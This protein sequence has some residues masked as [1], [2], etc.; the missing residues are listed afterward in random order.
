MSIEA[1]LSR[2][3]IPDDLVVDPTSSENSSLYDEDEKQLV[4]T[5][6]P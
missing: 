1:G 5:T 2:R 3:K 6:I 4:T